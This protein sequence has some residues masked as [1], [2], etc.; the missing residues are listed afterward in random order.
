M[1]VAHNDEVSVRLSGEQLDALLACLADPLSDVEDL[2]TVATDDVRTVLEGRRAVLRA[3][4]TLLVEARTGLTGGK[5]PA[6]G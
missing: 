6:L 5:D 3:L 4:R 2:L 1:H